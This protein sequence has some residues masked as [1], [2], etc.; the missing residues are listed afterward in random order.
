MGERIYFEIEDELATPGETRKCL[1]GEDGAK[2]FHED[3]LAAIAAKQGCLKWI[4]DAAAG[5]LAEL[6]NS[7]MGASANARARFVLAS[8][9]DDEDGILEVQS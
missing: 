8:L 7:P 5:A 4:L 9:A 6:Y 3:E 1:I 2:W